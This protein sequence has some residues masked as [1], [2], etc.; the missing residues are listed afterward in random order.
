MLTDASFRQ[1]Y[2]TAIQNVARFVERGCFEYVGGQTVGRPI[3]NYQRME[4]AD[5]IRKWHGKFRGEA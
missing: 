5:R 2:D 1:G 4:Q 3:G